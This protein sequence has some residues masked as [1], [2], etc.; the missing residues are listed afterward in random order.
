MIIYKATN[1][2]NGK[3]YI[4]KTI[5]SLT[6]RKSSH[7]SDSFTGNR[8]KMPFHRAIKKYGSENFIWEVLIECAS[9]EN[10]DNMEIYYI[11]YFK[12][13]RP[14]GYNI[15]TG[16]LGGHAGRILSETTKIK[17]SKSKLGKPLRLSTSERRRRSSSMLG[18]NNSAFKMV[19]LHHNCAKH[20]I[21]TTPDGDSFEVS[22]LR[23][24][25][26]EW[27]KDTLYHSGLSNVASGKMKYHKG[28]K[29]ERAGDI[30]Q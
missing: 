20:Y 1:K 15:C 12:T 8:D 11:K 16:G 3:I 23:K 17:I 28:Y 18:K 22:G 30:K 5:N 21:I 19:G 4:G 27:S 24:F 6:K 2:I 14:L 13:I 29:C 10:L 26:R 25:C 7:I 9:E